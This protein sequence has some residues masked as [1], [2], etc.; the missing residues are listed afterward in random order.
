[1]TLIF[2]FFF[3]TQFTQTHLSNSYIDEFTQTAGRPEFHDKQ[4][5]E[6]EIIGHPVQAFHLIKR[7][8]IHWKQLQQVMTSSTESWQSK[9]KLSVVHLTKRTN[10][11][12]SKN[13]RERENSERKV[14][15]STNHTHNCIFVCQLC[16]WTFPSFLLSVNHVKLTHEG[17]DDD[18]NVYNCV[19]FSSLSFSSSVSHSLFSLSIS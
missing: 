15:H 19:I 7:L 18:S 17:V 5:S 3:F 8:T 11:M 16:M 1:M 10:R 4:F 6:E 2:A 12:K 13:E 14:V 9:E